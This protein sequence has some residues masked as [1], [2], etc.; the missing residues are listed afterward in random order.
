MKKVVVENT[1]YSLFLY[2]LINKGGHDT[3]FILSNTID[4]GV[5]DRI[6]SHSRGVYIYKSRS[7][8]SL[9]YKI[10]SFYKEQ[11]KLRYFYNKS[12]KGRE[13]EVFG[14]DDLSFSHVFIKHGFNII[15]DGLGNYGV[16]K[17]KQ[18]AIK[19]LILKL[20]VLNFKNYEPLGYDKIVKSIYLTGTLDI[21]ELLASKVKLINPKRL[22]DKLTKI[23]KD[24][25]LEVFGI[26]ANFVKKLS[27]RTIIVFTQCLSE[28]GFIAEEVKIEIYKKLLLQYP[29]SDVLIKT[30]PREK[31]NYKNIF[32]EIE[33]IDTPFP[34]E[35]LPLIGSDFK[36][37]V[38]LFSAAATGFNKNIK[39]DF[40]GT[41]FDSRLKDKFGVIKF[42]PP[43][44]EY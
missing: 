30:H 24:N 44:E 35:I 4:K 25:I 32:P 18:Y 16:T 26:D 2:M 31:T 27:G 40:Y 36:K 39:V 17:K 20:A 1:L 34:S 42:K 8:G 19:K 41:E 28:D 29:L 22:W 43:K 23:E 13:L 11:V 15:E 33:V 3:F 12:F 10:Y 38:T 6:K 14:N 7:D 9:F 21:P 37:V 5:I